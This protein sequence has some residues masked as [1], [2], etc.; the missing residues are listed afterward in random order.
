MQ[1]AIRACN[2]AAFAI[3]GGHSINGDRKTPSFATYRACV[4]GTMRP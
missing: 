3:H 1:V 4:F 2:T